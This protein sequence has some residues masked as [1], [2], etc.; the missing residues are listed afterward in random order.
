[1]PEFETVSLKEAQLRI[2][3]GRGGKPINEYASYIL[4]LPIGQ[5]GKLRILEN[6]KP[7]TIRRRLTQAGK[8]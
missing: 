7:A 6:E 5:A 1:M 4:E 2:I 3:P 8:H